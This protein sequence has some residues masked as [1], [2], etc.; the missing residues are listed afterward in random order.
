M[1][2]A[3]GTLPMLSGRRRH[4]FSGLSCA[5]AIAAAGVFVAIV[6]AVPVGA[7]VVGLEALLR[8]SPSAP[9]AAFSDGNVL[10]CAGAGFAGAIQMGSHTNASAADANVAGA[11]AT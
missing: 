11:A 6:G 7:Q 2:D 1:G 8:S 4:R 3:V 10:T 5:L 9:R